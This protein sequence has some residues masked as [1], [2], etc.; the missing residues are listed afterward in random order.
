M[1]PE[2]SQMLNH[3]QNAMLGFAPE[4][5]GNFIS[6]LASA[7][8]TFPPYDLYKESD[9]VYVISIAAAGFDKSDFNI[10][11]KDQQL[12]IIGKTVS[13]KDEQKYLHKGIATRRFV[14]SFLLAEHTRVESASYENGILT[15]KVIRDLPPEIAPKQIPIL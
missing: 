4:W 2:V 3:A 15:I 14:K 6:S 8:E 12:T 13:Q 9:D 7:S 1:K 5:P 11:V 10:S